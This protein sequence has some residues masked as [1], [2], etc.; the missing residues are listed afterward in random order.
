MISLYKI[1]YYIIILLKKAYNDHNLSHA[2]KFELSK[3]IYSFASKK[4]TFRISFFASKKILH[5]KK[6]KEIKI[7]KKYYQQLSLK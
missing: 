1:Y 6:Y 7:P 3:N 5:K 4:F 2:H